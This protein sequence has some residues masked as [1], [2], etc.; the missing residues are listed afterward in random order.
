MATTASIDEMA[1]YVR[2]HFNTDTDSGLKKYIDYYPFISGCGCMGPTDGWSV[3]DCVMMD[4]V[5]T[6]KLKI[7]A[8]INEQAALTLMRKQLI[9]ALGG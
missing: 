7:L 4:L 8:Q 9:K 6:N 5:F 2:A 3:C 1:Q